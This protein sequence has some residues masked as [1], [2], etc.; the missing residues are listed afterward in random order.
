[1]FGLKERRDEKTGDSRKAGYRITGHN[2]MK[3]S[4]KNR[5]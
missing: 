5:K 3:V 1:M 4:K 2:I